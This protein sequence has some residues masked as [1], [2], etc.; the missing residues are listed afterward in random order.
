ML[1]SVKRA[2]VE[3]GKKQ[4]YAKRNKE[5]EKRKVKKLK[6]SGGIFKNVAGERVATAVPRFCVE[7]N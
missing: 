3:A 4:K 6:R 5:E 2:Q 7:R 1:R